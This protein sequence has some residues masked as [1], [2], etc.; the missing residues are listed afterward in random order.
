MGC[1]LGVASTVYHQCPRWRALAKVC[2]KHEQPPLSTDPTNT[3]TAHD[4]CK[5]RA[6]GPTPQPS[7][8]KWPPAPASTFCYHIPV[9]GEHIARQP[10]TALCRNQARFCGVLRTNVG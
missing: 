3:S 10:F 4:H 5:Y 9:C 7:P 2:A 8:P 1:T 6:V